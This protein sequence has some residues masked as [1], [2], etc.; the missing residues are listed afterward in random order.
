[1]MPSG[2]EEVVTGRLQRGDEDLASHVEAKI[3]SGIGITFPFR[4]GTIVTGE[5]LKLLCDDRAI[6]FVVNS[7]IPEPPGDEA[8]YDG[9]ILSS[10]PT[11]P[12]A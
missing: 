5:M 11:E 6:E 4:K 8:T 10:H 7:E 1:M 3:R 2:A 9:R 12:V